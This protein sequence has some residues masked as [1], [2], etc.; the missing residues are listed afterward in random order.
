MG[1]ATFETAE[2]RLVMHLLRGKCVGGA[3][4]EGIDPLCEHDAAGEAVAPCH[5]RATCGVRLGDLYHCGWDRFE[6]DGLSPVVT[7][8]AE[9]GEP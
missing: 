9:P 3:G 2:H 8:E 1:Q 7:S 6:Q 4:I 5:N